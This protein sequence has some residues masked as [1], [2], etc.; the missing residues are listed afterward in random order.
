MAKKIAGE[1]DMPT[2]DG[3]VKLRLEIA[4]MLEL[5]DLFE[6]GSVRLITDVVQ[7][8]KT[9]SLSILLLAMTGRDF[10]DEGNIATAINEILEI[11]VSLV[12]TSLADCIAS[13][14]TA[15]IKPRGKSKAAK[16]AT[17]RT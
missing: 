3:P 15:G 14:I 5:E 6:V 2:V 17:S 8:M 13:T 7:P 10:N 9:R 12:S 16:T 4:T 11:G 1:V